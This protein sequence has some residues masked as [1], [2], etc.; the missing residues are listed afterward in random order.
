MEAN[1]TTSDIRY[2]LALH[3]IPGI[4]SMTFRFL[5]EQV[6]SP[7][8]VF[9]QKRQSLIALGLNEKILDHIQG[10]DWNTVDHDL[11]WLEIPDNHLVTINNP[12][13][14]ALLKEIPDPPPLLFIHGNISVLSL[15]QVAIV[16]SRNPTA[17]GK[18]H[19]HD[20]AYSLAGTGLAI[21]SG[22]A[23]GIDSAG[24]NG[25]MDCGGVTIAVTGNGLDR[26][27]PAQ[28]KSMA[29]QIAQNGALISEFPPGT[30]P[31]AN[32]FPRRNR[33]ISGLSL[34]VLVIEAA[35]QSGSLITARLAMEQGREVFAVPGSIQNPLSRGCHALLREGAKL[36]ETVQDVL[37]EINP[38]ADNPPVFS[39]HQP[40][41]DLEKGHKNLLD[42]IA[43]DPTPVDTLVELIGESP[44]SIASMLLVLE[45]NGYISS[46]A[47][48]CYYR[49]K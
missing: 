42:H 23:L 38:V 49:V 36:V 1:A 44:E 9:S 37:E 47:G 35:R 8:E 32:N 33:I 27:Y 6:G 40:C 26:V 30:P 34:G 29:K 17:M 21:T 3:R 14:P 20:F 48:G 19:A 41:P 18:R 15:P 16:G 39:E 46:A 10:P 4:G 31:S 45:L 5:L 13:Y 22:L 24:H 11:K 28:H 2:W 25:A 12:A 7:R 43:Y